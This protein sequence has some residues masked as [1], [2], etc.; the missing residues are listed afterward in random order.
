VITPLTLIRR[1]EKFAFTYIIADFLILTTAIV[2]FIFACLHISQKKVWAEGIEP[3]NKE[4][5]LT[6]IGSAIFAF[7][8][9]GVVIPIA[10]VTEKPEKLPIILLFVLLTNLFL[11]TGFG[12]FCLL[13]Y[14]DE[15]KNPLITENLHFGI[16]EWIIKLVFS[17]N[18][19]ISYTL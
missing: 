4:T 11:Y 5:Y 17:I 2:I 16:I 8:G 1:I 14:G 3:L 9:I 13:V 12:E 10:E 18:V 6:M 19:V 15:L 7:E